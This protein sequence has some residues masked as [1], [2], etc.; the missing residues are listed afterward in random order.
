MAEVRSPEHEEAARFF[1]R[2]SGTYRDKYTHQSA[3]HRY[4]FNERLEKATRGMDLRGKC[5]LDIGSG[6][7]NLYDHLIARAPDLRFF[8]TDVSPGMLA[9]SR[10][11]PAQRF[12]GHAYAHAFP[13]RAFDAIFLLGVTTYLSPEEL[14]R[15][16]AFMA[17]SLAPG[18]VAVITFSNRH[19]LDT[20]MRALF[21]LPSRLFGNRDRVLSS[22]LRTRT[23]SMGEVRRLL[24]PHL[25]I[26]R[27]DVHNHTVFP[28]GALLPGPSIALAERLARLPADGGPPPAWLR[29]LSSDLMVRAEPLTRM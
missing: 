10:V 29:F 28:F 19:G 2:V 20:G 1:D 15:N 11:P 21:R 16:L 12:V 5:V 7:G 9:Q 27:E 23:Y 24:Q 4:Y 3:F 6:T 8:A 26:V 22:G 18:G 17:G 25:R 13:V 14:Q